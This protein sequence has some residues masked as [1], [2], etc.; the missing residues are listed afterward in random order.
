[1]YLLGLDVGTT[2]WKA[3]L[4]DLKGKLIISVSH[5]AF[6]KKDK[7]GNN[8][9]DAEQMWKIFCALIRQVV[10]KVRTPDLIKAVSFASM[11]EAGCLADE[12]GLPLTHIIPWFDQR[13]MPQAEKILRRFPKKEIFGITGIN[14]T[15]IFSICKIMWFKEYEKTAFK[16]AAK[17]VCVPDYLI[18]RMSGEW[19]TDYSIASRTALFNIRNKKW[20]KKMLDLAGIKGSFLPK[21]FPSGTVAGKITEKASKECGLSINTKVVLGG[22]DHVCGS[23]GVG[24]FSEGKALDSMGTA[25]CICIPLKNIDNLKKYYNSGFSFGCYTYGNM[26][27][28][29]SGLYYSGGTI[30]WFAREYYKTGEK[31]SKI[32]ETMI[33]DADKSKPGSNGLYVFPHW[34]GIGA[35]YGLRDAR[36][37]VLGLNPDTTKGDLVNAVYEGLAYEYRFLL[38]T[39]EKTIGFKTKEIVV[40]GGGAKNKLWLKRK[41]DILG[42]TLTVPKVPESVCFG[43]ALQAGIG[44]GIIKNPVKYVNNNK[45]E[46]V[47]NEK[48][49]KTFY[50]NEYR[51]HYMKI[52]RQNLPYWEK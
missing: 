28:A 19:A 14:L 51:S 16:R 30:E 25:E 5:P 47:E 34:L 45:K 24:L 43:A 10:K 27:Y 48:K 6:V 17:W 26:F 3:N 2:N 37:I 41:A 15:Y 21:A 12:E 29:M 50:N 33:K 46:Y 4:Y 1:M 9:Y 18:K 23:L 38:E 7:C 31:K 32:Y 39:A 40:I 49:L 22:H 52:Y 36:G 42:K 8:Y 44:A 13:T 11:A 35:P 20:S